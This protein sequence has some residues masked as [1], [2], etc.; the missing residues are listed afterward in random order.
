MMRKATDEKWIEISEDFETA[1]FDDSIWY[2]RVLKTIG[3]W[4]FN[5]DLMGFHGI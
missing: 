2:L 3:K 5:G 1:M 4:W